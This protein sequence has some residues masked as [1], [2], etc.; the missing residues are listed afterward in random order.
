[1]DIWPNSRCLWKEP[2]STMWH[3][4]GHIHPGPPSADSLQ[5]LLQDI[6]TIRLGQL[7]DSH[8]QS[9]PPPLGIF[10]AEAVNLSNPNADPSDVDLSCPSTPMDINQSQ[11]RPK[12]HTCYNCGDKG[13]LSHVCPKPQKQRI[14]LDDSAKGDIKSIVAE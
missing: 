5:G 8:V 13:H 11:P 14:W 9:G 4:G 6:I 2:A 10:Q 3:P 12:I 7:D 1:M